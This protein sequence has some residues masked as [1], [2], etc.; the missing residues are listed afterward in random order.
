LP[1]TP[2]VFVHE[3]ENKGDRSASTVHECDSKGFSL[4]MVGP[5]EANSLQVIQAQY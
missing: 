3:C 5:G 2:R 1:P 4:A